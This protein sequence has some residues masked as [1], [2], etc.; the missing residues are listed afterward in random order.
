MIFPDLPKHHNF[1][2]KT[3]A[4]VQPVIAII[5]EPPK[6]AKSADEWFAEHFPEL[7]NTVQPSISK[8]GEWRNDTRGIIEFCLLCIGMIIW[9]AYWYQ[10]R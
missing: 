5:E 8:P 7:N 4:D 10:L 6:S 1:F 9:I 2:R 3:K